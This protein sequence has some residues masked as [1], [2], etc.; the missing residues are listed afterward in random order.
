MIYM[1]NY[2]QPNIFRANERYEILTPSGFKK[3][4]GVNKQKKLAKRLEFEDGSFLVATLE[5]L[6]LTPTGWLKVADCFNGTKICG[7]DNYDHVITYI[8]PS[9]EE[10]VFD[11]INVADVSLYNSGSVISHNCSFLST[12]YTL[13]RPDVLK[14]LV[15]KKPIST[16][17]D[18]YTEF[19]E[20]EKDHNYIMLVDTASGQGLDYSTFVIADVTQIPYRVVATYA[21][22]KISTIEFPQVLMHYAKRYNMPWLMV[23][24]M[25]IGRD[26]AFIMWRDFEYPRF[27]AT[28]TEKRLGQR[29]VFNSRVQRHLGLRMTTGVKRSGCAVIKALVENKQLILNDYRIIQQLSAFVQSGSTYRAEVNHHDD[30]VMPLVMFGWISLQPNFTEITNARVLDAYIQTEAPENDD[31][32]SHHNILPDAKPKEVDP[33]PFGIMDINGYD[34]DSS[35]LIGGTFKDEFGDDNF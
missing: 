4:D 29:L 32:P 17:E 31:V 35:W 34:D 33:F 24:V 9:Y 22:N 16:S 11:P 10:W 15:H 6:L 28:M 7:I 26:V 13:I 21:N 18:G 30:L 12:Q 19:F 27:M 8:S 25:D 20:P 14:S 23:E 5:H 3:F 1:N 2:M